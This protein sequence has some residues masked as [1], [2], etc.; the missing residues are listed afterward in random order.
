MAFVRSEDILTATVFERLAYLD[1]PVLWALLVATFK[2]RIL[3]ERKVA[4]LTGIEFWPTWW[5]AGEAAGGSVEPDV[6][7]RFSIGDPPVDVVLVVEC[8]LGGLQYPDQWA[9]EW[10]AAQ[11]EG[12]ADEAVETYLIALGGL[13]A[14][15]ETVVEAFTGTLHETVGIEVK[16]AA[17]DWRDLLRAL[18]EL[19]V[20]R[21]PDRRIVSDVK[22]ALALHGYAE[23]IPMGGLAAMVP[24]LGIRSGSAGALRWPGEPPQTTP[25]ARSATAPVAP[26]NDTFAGWDNRV[27]PFLGLR[28]HP[29]LRWSADD[30][31]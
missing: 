14:S 9:R 3:P 23:H 22:A 30:V 15:A 28:D 8:K 16:A 5:P 2:P 4:E 29:N 18:D 24:S 31:R 26:V 6:V 7:M 12:A 17:A 20:A 10:I 11:G 27:S 13:P 21:Q 1:G 25:A 19:D